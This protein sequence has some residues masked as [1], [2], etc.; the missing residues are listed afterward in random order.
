MA[1]I[2]IIGASAGIGLAT[3]KAGLARGH[4]IIAFARSADSMSIEHA[5]LRQVAGDAL[6]AVDVSR[7]LDGADVVVLTLGIA[8]DLRMLT[9]PIDLFSAATRTLLP[10]M[11][12]VG[13]RR[14]IAVTGFGFDE[15]RSSI[16]PLQRIGFDLVFGRAYADKTIQEQL[17]AQSGLDWT[18]V[19]PGVLTNGK[20]SGRYKILIKSQEWRNGLIS[21]ADVADFI[22]NQ[23]DDDAFISLAPVLVN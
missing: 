3:T 15:S 6:K 22:L 16:G 8:A 11:H 19:R 17:I 18:I 21:R 12:E 5:M 14:L 2:L 20:A 7:A 10:L 23:V 9:G 4:S 13:V 1:T